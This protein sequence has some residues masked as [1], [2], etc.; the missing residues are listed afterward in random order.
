MNLRHTYVKHNTS[1]A[2][3]EHLLTLRKCQQQN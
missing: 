1:V 2:I 3:N